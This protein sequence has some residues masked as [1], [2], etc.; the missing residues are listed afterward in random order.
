MRVHS[1]LLIRD[2]TSGRETNSSLAV[3]TVPPGIQHDETYSERSDKYY[4]VLSGSIQ[5]TLERDEFDLVAGDFCQVHRGQHF[6]YKNRAMESAIIILFH[7]PSFE[8]E[9]EVFVE[10]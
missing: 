7:T 4:Y 3:I 1:G 10:G 6:H 8:L 5:F 9:A 2:Y